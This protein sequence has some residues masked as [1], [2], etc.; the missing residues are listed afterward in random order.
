[1]SNNANLL[2]ETQKVNMIH[3]L[4]YLLETPRKIHPLIITNEIVALLY[5][6]LYKDYIII[7]IQRID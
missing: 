7:Y 4:N 2:L 5:P 6:W 1:M 3:K